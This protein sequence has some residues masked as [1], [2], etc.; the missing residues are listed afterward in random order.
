M[1]ESMGECVL[2]FLLVIVQ[3][4]EWRVGRRRYRRE[5]VA[6]CFLWK[7]GIT[8]EGKGGLCMHAADSWV[9]LV[10]VQNARGHDFLLPLF[11]Q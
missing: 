11:S 10:Q 5:K 8:G 6:D 9:G 4:G 7:R 2:C 3:G 1:Q